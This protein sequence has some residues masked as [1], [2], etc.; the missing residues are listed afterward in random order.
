MKSL[1]KSNFDKN[2]AF[3]KQSMMSSIRGIRYGSGVVTAFRRLKSMQIRTGPSFF[4][5]GIIGLD[6]GLCDG[7]IMP[8]SIK[9]SS[10]SLTE[11]SRDEGIL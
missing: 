4:L 10:D 1:A 7:S 6:Q 9:V 11:L 2:F 3:P 8:S 5:T